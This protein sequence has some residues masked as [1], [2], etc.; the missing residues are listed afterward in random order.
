MRN[1]NEQKADAPVDDAPF[2][3]PLINAEQ[4][5]TRRAWLGALAALAGGGALS[6][7]AAQRAWAEPLTARVT[8]LPAMAYVYAT[9]NRT[10]CNKW[11]THLEDHGFDV[12]T[13][14]IADEVPFKE[15]FGVPRQLWSC[16]TALVGNLVIEGH[17]PA[18]LIRKAQR[19]TGDIAG[20]SVPGMPCGAPGLEGPNPETY[21]VI[22][23]TKTGRTF[24]YAT[25]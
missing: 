17:V 11:C 19:E 10:C 23:F 6:A 15:K 4:P 16:H 8:R 13:H 21:Q 9:P 20:L 12:T 22:A 5:L 3:T 7:L 24:V 2:C 1:P 14:D 25:R 18:D